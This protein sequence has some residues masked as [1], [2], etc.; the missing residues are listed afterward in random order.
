M[1]RNDA[2]RTHNVVTDVQSLER[3]LE[4]VL[5]MLDRVSHYVSQVVT[6]EAP[7]SFAIGQNL[8]NSLSLAPNLDAVEVEKLFNIH[9]QDVLLVSYLA[10]VVRTQ[11]KIFS[12]INN[13][14]KV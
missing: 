8:I 5:V 10:N 6:D 11:I 4:E 9:L 7:A 2:S 1:G 13:I 14:A 3:G 12:S